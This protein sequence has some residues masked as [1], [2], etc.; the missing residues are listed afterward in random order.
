MHNLDLTLTQFLSN[1]LPHTTFLDSFFLFISAVGNYGFI[2]ILLVV[3]L[4]IIEEVKH[5]EF[6]PLFIV[7]LLTT[8]LVINGTK[9]LIKRPRPDYQHALATEQSYA[10]PSGHAATSF[11][12]ATLLAYYLT[13]DEK[14]KKKHHY[15]WSGVLYGVAVLIA[16]SRIYLGVHYLS[17]VIIG[18]VIGTLIAK[19]LIV[20]ATRVKLV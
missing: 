1:I 13:Q 6:L 14:K 4:L 19:A 20:L 16:Y 9:R 18:A 7:G 5:H 3:I 11:F 2:F 17:D 12:S 15:Y 8:I 10:F